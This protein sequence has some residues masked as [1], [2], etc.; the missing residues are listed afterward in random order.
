MIQIALYSVWLVI[1]LGFF[2]IALWSALELTGKSGKRQNP[3]D[4]FRQGFF[5]L[6]CAIICIIID[7]TFL[8]FF[9]ENFSPSFIPLGFYQVILLPLVLYIGAL[10]V[11][12]S[13]PIR[14]TKGGKAQP[15]HRRR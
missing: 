3:G 4:F 2:V 11:G 14:V 7:Q 8:G 13:K 12:P 5:T 10:T 1:P 6:V 15:K 9:V